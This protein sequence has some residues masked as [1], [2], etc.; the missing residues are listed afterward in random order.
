M[1]EVGAD[2]FDFS[3]GESEGKRVVLTKES[4]WRK[5]SRGIWRVGIMEMGGVQW[6][7]MKL[8]KWH[9]ISTSQGARS[10]T[11]VE[12]VDCQRYG[13]YVLVTPTKKSLKISIPNCHPN[14]G[15]I[16]ITIPNVDDM[17]S[18]WKAWENELRA[19]VAGDLAGGADD[20]ASAAGSQQSIASLSF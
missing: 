11:K 10:Y 1:F 20:L 9:D 3:W 4:G 8:E 15:D 5:I 17:L 16:M 14:G 7:L 2:W 18:G 12:N 6:M 19:F 13:I